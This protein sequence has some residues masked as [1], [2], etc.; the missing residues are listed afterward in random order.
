MKVVSSVR[1]Y[2][3]AVT[4]CGLALA[5]AWPLDAPSSCFFLAVM[6]SSLYAGRGPG[7]LAAILSAFA[8]NYFFLAP[9]FHFFIEPGSF[10]RFA[11]FLGA[12]LLITALIE[13][14]RRVEET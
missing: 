4:C 2:G 10:L 14:K 3:L 7:L 5:V 12:L 9:R 6:V 1:R 13:T 11:V 8:F